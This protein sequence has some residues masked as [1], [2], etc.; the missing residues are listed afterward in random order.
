[1]WAEQ[2]EKLKRSSANHLFISKISVIGHEYQGPSFDGIK[3]M[4]FSEV[5]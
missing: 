5:N 4:Y 2:A 1:M 3:Q